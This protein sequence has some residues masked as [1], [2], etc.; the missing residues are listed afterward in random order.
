M[1]ETFKDGIKRSCIWAVL[2]ISFLVVLGGRRSGEK[3]FTLG[4]NK[5]PRS[6]TRIIDG[7]KEGMVELGYVE[8]KNVKYNF[9]VGSN[10]RNDQIVDAEV[11]RLL[12]QDI[13][14]IFTVYNETAMIVKHAVEGSDTPVIA[15][16]CNR[17]VETGLV[18]SLVN[19]GGNVTGIQLSDSTSKGFEWL[20]QLTPHAKKVYLPYNF[21]NMVSTQPLDEVKK[22]ASQMGIELVLQKINSVEEAIAAIEGLP[23]DIDAIYW[24]PSIAIGPKSKELS[25]AA[26]KRGLPMGSGVV[27]DETVLMTFTS[28]PFKMGKQAAHL[29]NQIHQG[30]KPAALP[31]ETSEVYLTI[32]LKTAEKIGLKIPDQIL[33]QANKI[34][35]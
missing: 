31:M 11:K 28:D 8:G 17:P 34:I 29:A 18:K 1:V 19:P 9:Y 30:I 3:I 7:F 22:A 23:K 35:R 13:D 12:D 24:V 10:G 4:I 6:Q 32:N 14:L 16:A 25:N 15:I 5:F 33:A 27:L 2:I 20:V 21:D 26:I